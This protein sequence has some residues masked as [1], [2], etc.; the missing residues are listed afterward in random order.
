[1]VK[2]SRIMSKVKAGI[3]IKL[4]PTSEEGVPSPGGGEGDDKSNPPPDAPP[5]EETPDLEGKNECNAKI[6]L[7]K[8]LFTHPLFFSSEETWNRSQRG[9]EKDGDGCWRGVGAIRIQFKGQPPGDRRVDGRVCQTRS[10]R[11]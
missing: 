11:H 5:T 1:M 2:Q 9:I 8:L 4:N 6:K 7:G 3:K 10:Q